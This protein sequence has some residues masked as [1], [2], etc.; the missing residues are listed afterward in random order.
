MTSLQAAPRPPAGGNGL[1]GRYGPWAL[2]TGASDGIGR[3][4]AACLAQ[5]GLD[6]VLVA[7]RRPKLERIAAELAARHGIEA[8]ILALDLGAPESLEAVAAATAELEVGLLVACAGFGTSGGFLESDGEA[9]LDMVD[10]NCRAVLGLCKAFARDFAA[11]KRGGLILMSSLLAFQGVPLAANYAATKAYVQTLAEGLHLELAPLGIDVLACAPG[12]IHSGFAARA[13]MR[14]GMG[15]RPKDIAQATLD[16]LGRRTTVR[17][18][19]LAKC[20]EG[21]MVGLPRWARTRILAQVMRGMTK[22][23]LQGA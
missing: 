19:W 21:S 6:L 20:L 18:G 11:R 15:Q 17:P 12:P 4:M 1:R 7:R 14:M 13:G 2:V 9:E 5:A 16:A 22:H 10:V 3:E 23:R 8:R